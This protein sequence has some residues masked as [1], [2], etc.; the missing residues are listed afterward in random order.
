VDLKEHYD[1]KKFERAKA[2]AEKWEDE[3]SHKL[4]QSAEEKA[5]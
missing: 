4:A 2:L 3:V 5:H 1:Q